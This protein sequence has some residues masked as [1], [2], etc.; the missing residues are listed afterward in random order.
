MQ[1]GGESGDVGE[2]RAVADLDNWF[3]WASVPKLK[4]GLTQTA[5]ASCSCWVVCLTPDGRTVNSSRRGNH[6]AETLV[7]KE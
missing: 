2:N 6:C 7:S 4:V 1:A 3:N 5:E